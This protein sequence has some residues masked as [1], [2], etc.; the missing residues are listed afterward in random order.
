MMQTATGEESF[1]RYLPQFEEGI[2]RFL[3]GDP[4][5]WKLNA[6]QGDDVTVMG[7]WG[8]YEQGWREAGPR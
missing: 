1:E 3:S 2:A 6:S 7:A 5:P 4:M 8:A